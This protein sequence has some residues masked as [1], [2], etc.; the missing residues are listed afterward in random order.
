[1]PDE[2]P[3]SKQSTE[4][5]KK[6]TA[7]Q[8]KAVRDAQKKVQRHVESGKPGP[9]SDNVNPAPKSNPTE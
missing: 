1:M 3:T 9:S 2:I 4:D 8:P 7:K 6:R 5:A